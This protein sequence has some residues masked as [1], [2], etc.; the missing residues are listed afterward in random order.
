MVFKN[1][2][3]LSNAEISQYKIELENEFNAM[4]D[5]INAMCDELDKIEKEYNNAE[6]ELKIRKGGF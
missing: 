4:R 3:E 6:N 1:C 2:K 5:K